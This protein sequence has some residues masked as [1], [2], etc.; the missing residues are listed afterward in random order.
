MKGRGIGKCYDSSRLVVVANIAEV[1]I[2]AVI[3][4]GEAT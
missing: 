4:I 3:V 2:I 1:V